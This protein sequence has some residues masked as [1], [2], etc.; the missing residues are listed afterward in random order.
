MITKK[1][2]AQAARD[3]LQSLANCETDQEARDGLQFWAGVM[4]AYTHL[5]GY[6]SSGQIQ[7]QINEASEIHPDFTLAYE[8]E[9]M[10]C[11]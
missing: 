9:I 2:R 5:S 4:E 3:A 7:D 10:K 11:Q 8:T 1:D 6:I